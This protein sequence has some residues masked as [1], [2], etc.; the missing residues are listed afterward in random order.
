[1]ARPDAAALHLATAARH[2]PALLMDALRWL[3][4]PVQHASVCRVGGVTVLDAI[5]DV[6]A[7][8]LQ[9]VGCLRAALVHRL[10]QSGQPAT[11]L[12]SLLRCQISY[13]RLM[14]A[15]SILCFTCS[16]AKSS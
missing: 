10:Q 11:C 6:P 15:F 2:A 12:T 3:D 5:V 4:L 14:G 7:T 9:D 1:M 8:A 16:G 13:F